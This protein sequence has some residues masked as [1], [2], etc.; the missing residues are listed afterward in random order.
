MFELFVV[1]GGHFG[2]LLNHSRF[3]SS[4]KDYNLVSLDS[5]ALGGHFGGLF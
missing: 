2:S 5:L 1:V 4:L 3:G